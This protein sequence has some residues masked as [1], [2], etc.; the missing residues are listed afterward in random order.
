M[1]LLGIK[2]L[3]NFI[4]ANP[5]PSEKPLFPVLYKLINQRKSEAYH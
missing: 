3:Q 5:L 2:H 4:K 1:K